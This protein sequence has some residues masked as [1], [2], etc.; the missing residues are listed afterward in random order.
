MFR[1]RRR[2]FPAGIRSAYASELIDAESCD[3]RRAVDGRTYETINQAH[4]D[5]P[6]EAG[7]RDAPRR[8]AVSARSSSFTKRRRRHRRSCAVAPRPRANEPAATILQPEWLQRRDTGRYEAASTRA[9]Q[10]VSGMLRY[11]D[12]SVNTTDW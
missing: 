12:A 11:S 4:A 8:E 2:S 6:K 1:R 9:K 3:A 10:Q 5:S 7:T